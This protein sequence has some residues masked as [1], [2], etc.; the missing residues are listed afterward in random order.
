[1][2]QTARKTAALF[3]V[4]VTL[5]QSVTKAWN[6]SPNTVP[7]VLQGKQWHDWEGIGLCP[8]A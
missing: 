8:C 7:A 5:S 1:M 2:T 3:T 6:P 4:A